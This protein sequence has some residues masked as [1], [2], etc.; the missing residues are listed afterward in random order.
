MVWDVA[1]LVQLTGCLRRVGDRE[2]RGVRRLSVVDERW[3]VRRGRRWR[4][5]FPVTTLIFVEWR[6]VNGS[7]AAVVL[8]GPITTRHLVTASGRAGLGEVVRPRRGSGR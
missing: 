8:T 7:C 5:H 4:T 1:D 2:E 6:R 3:S